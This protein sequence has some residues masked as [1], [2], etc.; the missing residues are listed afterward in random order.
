MFGKH[1]LSDVLGIRTEEIDCKP[2]YVENSI[3]YD[4]KTYSLEGL[5]ALIHAEDA[6]VLSVYEADFYKGTPALTKNHYGNGTAYFIV[7]ETGSELIEDLYKNIQKE[8]DIR[9]NFRAA[10]P[11]G[12]TVSERIGEKGSVY[13]LQN[14]R[15]TPV[16]VSLEEAYRE[17]ET[18]EI[19]YDEIEVAG[20]DCKILVKKDTK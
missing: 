20:Y 16:C 15:N 10:L 14:Y 6:E 4:G 3:S 1:P 18:G 7:A 5:C 13:F 8:T 17:M 11:E 12:V 19:F 2:S 9:S